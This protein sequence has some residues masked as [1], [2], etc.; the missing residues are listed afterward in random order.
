MIFILTIYD[1]NSQVFNSYGNKQ[2]PSD[3]PGLLHYEDGLHG[4]YPLGYAEI[5]FIPQCFKK[6]PKFPIFPTRR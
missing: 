3:V 2:A 1:M 6:F 5:L 4:D